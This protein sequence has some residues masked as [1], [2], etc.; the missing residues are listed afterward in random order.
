M[1]HHGVSSRDLEALR[2]F[3]SCTLSNAIELL[4]VRLRNEGYVRGDV[5]RCLFPNLPPVTGRAVTARMRSS[6]PPVDGHCYYDHIEWWRHLETVPPPRIV[7]MLDADDP[8][9]SG[10][11]FGSLHARICMAM[12]CVAYVTNGTVRDLPGIQRLGFQLFASGPAVSH[13]YAHVVDFG[14]PI[15]IGGL[16]IRPGDLLH[17][18]EHGILSIPAEAAGRLPALAAQLLHEEQD[19]IR[20]CIDGEFSIERLAQR[21][22]Q[23]AESQKCK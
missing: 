7:V 4:N 12:H 20:V 1:Q 10:A 14:H 19:F 15:E 23:H 2:R 8:P 16:T 5:V 22:R 17:A 13:A 18:D 9:G 3:D 11:L 6:S 21:L